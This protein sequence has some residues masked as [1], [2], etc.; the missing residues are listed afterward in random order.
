VIVADVMTREV[1]SV[2]PDQPL[3]DALTFFQENHIRHLPVLDDGRLVGILT[4]RDFKRATPSRV[5]GGSQEDFDRVLDETTISHVMT[6]EPWVVAPEADLK[7]V[8]ATFI[9]KKFGAVP[10]VKDGKLVGILS[11]VDL[12][13]VLLRLLS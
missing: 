13:K 4:D 2:H 1:V 11:D 8:T 12:L 9:G 10:V 7:A 6:R 3:R 5:S